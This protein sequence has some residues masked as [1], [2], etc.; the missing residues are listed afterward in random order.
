M[1]WKGVLERENSWFSAQLMDIQQPTL[2]FVLLSQRSIG[3]QDPISEK[4][5]AVQEKQ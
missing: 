1:C 3:I 5:A 2:R 4:A